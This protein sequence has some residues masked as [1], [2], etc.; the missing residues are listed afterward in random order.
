MSVPTTRHTVINCKYL[1]ATTPYCRWLSWSRA[2]DQIMM[3]MID[4]ASF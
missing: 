2:C 1:Q 4:D 3:M